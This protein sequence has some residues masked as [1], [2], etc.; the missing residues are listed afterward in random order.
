MSSNNAI[1]ALLVWLPLTTGLW[2]SLANGGYAATASEGNTAVSSPS[3]S[4]QHLAQS[5]SSDRTLGV[6]GS[7][8]VSAPAD[9]AIILMLFYANYTP[10]YSDPEAALQLPT[11]PKP[12]ELQDVVDALTAAGVPASNLRVTPDFTSSNG[13][14]VRVVLNQPSQSQVEQVVT[15]ATTAAVKENRF[16]LSTVSVGYT[17][18]DCQAIE[19]SARQAAIADVQ[20]RAAALA[21]AAGAEVGELISLSDSTVWGTYGSTSCPVNNDPVLLSNPYGLPPYDPSAPAV[22]N[23]QYQI[24]ATYELRN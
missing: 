17:T 23:V 14:R 13:L 2:G 19:N 8:Q 24:I 6:T 21:T 22:V 16:T 18:N 3:Q 4:V 11:V 15:T 5:V 1:S 9:Q 7:G 12:S 10:D 20:N